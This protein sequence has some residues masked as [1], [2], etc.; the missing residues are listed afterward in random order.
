MVDITKGVLNKTQKISLNLNEEFVDL[1]D[2]VGELTSKN[3]TMVLLAF[4]GKGINPLLEEMETTWKSLVI[5]GNLEASKK[6]RIKEL[7]EGLDKIRKDWEKIL[8]QWL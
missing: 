1:A 6:A 5:A 8:N 4:I 2:K 7:L 3:R